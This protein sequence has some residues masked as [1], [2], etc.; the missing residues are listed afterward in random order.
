MIP[1]SRLSDEIF[2]LRERV[3]AC[4]HRVRRHRNRQKAS[5]IPAAE[6]PG[7]TASPVL[8]TTG[9]TEDYATTEAVVGDPE[10]G[11]T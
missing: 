5:S 1:H 8:R 3:T 2:E 7:E 6:I 4:R 9:Y 11:I 10:A